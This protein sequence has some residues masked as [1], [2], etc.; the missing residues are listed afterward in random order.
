MRSSV[1]AHGPDPGELEGL[2]RSGGLR[3]RGPEV[4]GGSRRS[5]KA[6][7]QV[8]RGLKGSLLGPVLCRYIPP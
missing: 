6:S 4:S 2:Q 7:N 1:L 8:R 3:G 5:S